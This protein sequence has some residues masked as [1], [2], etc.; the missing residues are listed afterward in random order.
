MSDTVKKRKRDTSQKRDIILDGAIKVFTEKGFD[1]TSMDKIAEVANVS[2]RTIYNHFPSKEI[3]FQAIVDDFIT[4]R[5]EIKP[6]QYSQ[7]IPIGDQLKEFLFA[8]LYLIDDPVRRGLSRLLTSTFLLNIDLGN[9]IRGLYQTNRSFI[10]WLNEAK[11]D[12]RLS[13]E[14]AELTAHIFYGLIE[15]CMTWDALLTDGVSLQG[16][17][18][19]LDEIIAVFIMR[20]GC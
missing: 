5:E 15:G 19:L 3:L 6:I 14:S 8:E 12:N 1:A 9:E 2:K 16:T 4:H 11:K 10:T 20:Y 17:E 13:F 7:S 18:D